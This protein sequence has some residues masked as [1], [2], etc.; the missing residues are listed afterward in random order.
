[1]Q[2]AHQSD[3]ITHAVLGGQA[4]MSFGISD[5]P[6]FFQILSSALYKNPE[7][8]MVRETICNGWDSHIDSGCTDKPLTITIDR[9]KLVIRDY[10]KGIPAHL[11][12]PIYG[13]YGASTKK[14]DGRQTGGFGLGCKS[15]F[16]YSDHFEVV[17]CCDGV[18]TIYNMSKSSAEKMGKPSIV[19]I[20]SFPTTE[21]GIQV[22]IPV[23]PGDYS[24]LREYVMQVVFNGDIAA[25]VNG[26]QPETIK[27]SE[28][29]HGF[30]MLTPSSEHRSQFNDHK[31]F[32]R[33]GN[34]IY[35]VEKNQAIDAMYCKTVTMLDR[36]N[37]K[38]VLQAPAD[39]IS[40]TPSRESL[41]MS[42]ISIATINE[43]LRKFSATMLGNMH[44]QARQKEMVK[45]MVDVASKADDP[46]WNKLH[47]DD[48]FI[49]GMPKTCPS[50]ILR[51]MEDLVMMDTM[52]R[53]TDNRRLSAHTWLEHV[54]RF[55]WNAAQGTDVDMGSLSSWIKT[56]KQNYRVLNSP[57][58]MR[59][60][61]YRSES[62]TNK[63]E[64]AAA[65]KWWQKHVGMQ[66]LK[67]VQGTPG[68]TM[69]KFF[70]NGDNVFDLKYTQ[71]KVV[72]KEVTKVSMGNHTKNLISLLKPAVVL[73][74]NA[75]N[76]RSR[77]K[78]G[79]N[80][81]EYTSSM[82][83]LEF[84]VV[85]IP[86]K[87][88]AAE[89]AAAF[90]SAVP[91]IDF[92]D[93]TGRTQIEEADYRERQANAA[94][95]RAALAAG[96]VVDAPK[97]KAGTGMFRF[98]K[99]LAGS[100]IDTQLLLTDMAPTRIKE[101]VF[102]VKASTSMDL[103]HNTSTLIGEAAAAVA[104]LWG[105]Q[106]GVTN[107]SDVYDRYKEKGAVDIDAF[108]MDKLVKEIAVKPEIIQTMQYSAVKARGYLERKPY[109]SY[110]DAR[111]FAR[112]FGALLRY[113]ELQSLL[114]TYV[115]L[116]YEDRLRLVVWEHCVNGYATPEVQ[117]V[118]EEL[119]K[120]DLCQEAK[121]TLDKLADSKCM[122]FLSVDRMLDHMAANEKDPAAMQK[123][124][125]IINVVIK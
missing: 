72:L 16:A 59:G 48:W 29:E 86:R 45:D 46:L 74:H 34:V 35:P 110:S 122:S 68:F 19:P 114:P 118:R 106:G 22:T 42:D 103:R 61:Y 124:A 60:Y 51:S 6:A 94:A 95:K 41:T 33:Y 5:D 32:V 44:F 115:P 17:S 64:R 108:V 2:V 14:N 93:M 54:A 55:L 4:N 112:L 66:V 79:L 89:E 10:G 105:E 76:I 50:A 39:S 3:H 84:F 8:A 11:I 13:V 78:E 25:V 56:A 47:F 120:I 9:E 21:S 117:A 31:I 90:L 58:H 97:K 121:D 28:A 85:E 102:V 87:K 111:N 92:I 107:K 53:F 65:T 83:K 15:P 104:Q 49:P 57:A 18:R 24:T 62:R 52:T 101:P 81:R 123:I 73:C 109:L 100:R 67:K 116:S 82:R 99:L 75:A 27:L 7:Q 96:N 80:Y 38:V 26:E 71:S 1:M 125:E 91:G 98:D 77:V 43:L 63:Q 37:C 70:F 40:I 23:K 88:G 69:E 12:Q 113:Q 119:A 30:V 20:A 36:Y